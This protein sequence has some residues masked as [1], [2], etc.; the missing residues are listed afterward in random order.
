MSK[1]EKKKWSIGKKVVVIILAVIFVLLAAAVTGGLVY[2]HSYCQT[3]DYNIISKIGR[4]H[5]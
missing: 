2:L 3:K 5:V 4:A 1:A